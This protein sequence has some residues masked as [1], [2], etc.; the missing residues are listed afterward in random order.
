MTFK[1]DKRLIEQELDNPSFETIDHFVNL[2]EKQL[3]RLQM[4]AD[5]YLGY[6]HKEGE[7]DKT[8]SPHQKGQVFVNNAKYVTDIMVGITLGNPIAY[9][10]P[11]TDTTAEQEKNDDSFDVILENFDRINIARHDK[12]LEKD[13]SV[14]GVGYELFYGSVVNAYDEVNA[15]TKQTV[16]P[17]VTVIDPR[18]IFLVVDDTVDQEKL[19][20]VRYKEKRDL[21]D[22]SYWEFNIYTKTQVITYYSESKTLADGRLKF[23][24]PIVYEHFFGDVPVVE[25]RNNEEKQGDFEQ[26]LSQ[27]DAINRMQSDRVQDKKNHIR[28]MLITYGFALP[29]YEDD[30]ESYYQKKDSEVTV[31]AP[32]DARVEYVTNT[33]DESGVQVL[34]KALVDDFHKTAGVP[35]LNDE[36]FAGNISGEA[37][38]YKLL[39]LLMII[40]TKY[41][42][43]EDGVRQRLA[44]FAN[45]LNVQGNAIDTTGAEI[46]FKP[47]IPINQTEIIQQIRDSQDFVPLVTSLKWLPDIDDPV[48]QI[49]LLNRQKEQAIKLNQSMLGQQA[50][51]YPNSFEDKP[52]DKQE[53]QDERE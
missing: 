47:N 20:A 7:K 30:E 3:S 29:D 11:S 41:G 48:E 42:Y 1:I 53:T 14:F 8:K 34:Y 52:I 32:E 6:P 31:Q 39:G 25:Y 12:E 9:S 26:Q 44:L 36:N 10:S 4:L 23:E 15:T 50:S 46:K 33:F 5:Y 38:K 43:F 13:L 49:E 40:S 17:C 16:K 51:D 2:H 35:N 21:Q 45:F 37:M 22:Q 19:F 28:A 24:G 18:G 27:I